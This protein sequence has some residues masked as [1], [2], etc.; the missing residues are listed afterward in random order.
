M[1]NAHFIR[2][3]TSY[4]DSV[5][6]MVCVDCMT[7]ASQYVSQS[8]MCVRHDIFRDAYPM[9]LCVVNCVWWLTGR[10]LFNTF[11]HTDVCIF[12]TKYV[13]KPVYVCKA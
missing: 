2:W 11:R 13:S 10:W 9:F 4:L 12:A 6:T 7:F 5:L 1:M 3:V 8:C